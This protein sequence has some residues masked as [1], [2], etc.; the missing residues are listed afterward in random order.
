MRRILM[1]SGLVNVTVA[2]PNFVSY[3]EE[4]GNELREDGGLCLREG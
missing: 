4:D 2:Q 1:W 3:R